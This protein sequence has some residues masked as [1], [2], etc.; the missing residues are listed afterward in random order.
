MSLK[1]SQST[2]VTI[3]QIYREHGVKGFCKIYLYHHDFA[4]VMKPEQTL[5]LKK[6]KDPLQKVTLQKVMLFQRYFLAKFDI[7]TQPENI[8]EWRRAEILVERQAFPTKEG[9]VFDFEWFDVECFDPQNK[10]LGII[11]HII[12]TP[13][14]QFVLKMANHQ[15]VLIP[16][17]ESWIVKTDWTNKKVWLNLPD[18]IVPN[19][20]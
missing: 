3:G 6:K 2:H 10:R 4:V 16:F 7:F 5:F 8:K 19:Q 14:K 15:D 18:G 12:Y 1:N 11:T 20:K 9:H 13:L 17:V